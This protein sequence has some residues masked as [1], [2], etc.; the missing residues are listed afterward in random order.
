[1]P[2]A[3][4]G[5]STMTIFGPGLEKTTH[6]TPVDS[7]AT[8]TALSA[9]MT[10]G[11]WLLR[12]SRSSAQDRATHGQIHPQANSAPAE[13]NLFL[14][15]LCEIAFKKPL[16]ISLR[17]QRR[18]QKISAG[19]DQLVSAADYILYSIHDGWQNQPSVDQLSNHSLIC[20]AQSIF[21]LSLAV[22]ASAHAF[23][24]VAPRPS[25][26]RIANASGS[27]RL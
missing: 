19:Y 12:I 20:A 6:S 1:M 8:P 17:K 22:T 18:L 11:R 9:S 16:R 25:P 27:R 24:S 13:V 5:C 21:A 2:H 15:F 3:G 10:D 23:S 7:A 4:S 26:E 14:P